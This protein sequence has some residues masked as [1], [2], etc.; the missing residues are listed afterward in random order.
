MSG[1]VI[2]YSEGFKLEVVSQLESGAVR[3]FAQSLPSRS[4]HAGGGSPAIP[5]STR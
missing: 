4:V 3:G 5:G 1:K 2:R